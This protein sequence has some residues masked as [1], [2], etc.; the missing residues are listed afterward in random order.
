MTSAKERAMDA[1][2]IAK[3]KQF[4][5]EECLNET[6]KYGSDVYYFHFLPAAEYAQTLALQLHADEEVVVLAAL[7][8]D[9]GA[10]MYGREHHHVT[11]AQIAEQKLKEFGYAAEKIE[12]VK[13]CILHHR[14]SIPSPSESVEEQIIKDVDGMDAFDRLPGL[15]RAAYVYEGLSEAEARTSVRKKLANC[16]EKLS[17]SARI[18]VED[19]FRAVMLLLRAR[20]VEHGKH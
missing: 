7:L 14:G 17:L 12:K 5:K 1:E 15:F 13:K 6:S 16:Y 19:K 3:V 2:L 8:H 4:V 11:G 18:L 9:I 20:E 10:I